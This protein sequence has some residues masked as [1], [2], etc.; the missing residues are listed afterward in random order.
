MKILLGSPPTPIMLDSTKELLNPAVEIKRRIE[1]NLEALESMLAT[2]PMI[3]KLNPLGF[4]ESQL[5][6]FFLDRYLCPTP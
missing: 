5:F 1:L 3:Q 2:Q 6:Y 4:R